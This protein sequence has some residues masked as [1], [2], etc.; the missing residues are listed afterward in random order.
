MFV[1]ATKTQARLRLALIGPSGS[2]K[3]FSALSI[4]SGLA[5]GGRIALLDTERASASKYA[6]E[7][8]FDTAELETFHPAKYVE[9]IQQAEKA[10]YEVLIIDSLSHAWMGKDGALEQVDKVAARSR[11][12]NSFGAWR[13]VTP[14]HHALVDAILRSRCHVIA[15]MRAKTEWVLETNDKGKQTPRKVGLAPVQRD[16][17][18]YEFDVVGDLDATTLCIT[19]TRC[20]ALHQAVLKEPGA[21]LGEQLRAWLTD[22]APAMTPPSVVAPAP[23]PGVAGVTPPA[24]QPVAPGTPSRLEQVEIAINEAQTVK[25]LK[26]LVDA[27]KQLPPKEKEAVRPLYDRRRKDLSVKVAS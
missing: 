8:S 5:P 22:G 9:A 12:G 19:K 26:A 1:K 24:P 27:I 16:G 4:A 7:F 20:R 25:D 23:A 10:G 18:E 6:G 14:M 3:T 21:P 15:T 11:T 2:G 13:E 17:L